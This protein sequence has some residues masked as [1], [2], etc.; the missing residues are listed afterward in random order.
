M[1]YKILS[2]LFLFLSLST[3]AYAYFDPGMGSIIIQGIIGALAATTLTIKIYWKKI[4]D[5]FKKKINKNKK[6]DIE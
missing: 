2:F 3:N 1:L 5:F 6:K 4:R